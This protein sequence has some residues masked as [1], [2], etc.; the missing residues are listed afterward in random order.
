MFETDIRSKPALRAALK[1][2]RRELPDSER[3]RIDAAIA[4]Q[5]YRL[6]E[7]EQASTIFAYNSF[8]AEVDTHGIIGRALSEGK[9]VALPRCTPG[10]RRMRWY[11]IDGLDGLARSALGVYEPVPDPSRAIDPMQG[12]SELALVP[13]LS[14]D[15]HGYRL[16]YGGGFYDA[17]LAMFPGV[18][19][20]LCRE[21][22]MI[23]DLRRLDAREP[24]DRRV[25]IV[26]SD[27]GVVH[28]S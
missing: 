12:V 4:R 20:G 8:G 21:C 1:R 18:S 16:G 9:A 11:R 5:F 24:H 2:V 13:A 25:G 26:I 22:Q 27:A 3:A 17:F 15:I 6:P 19:V 14:F 28:A 10:T 23:G 7:Y